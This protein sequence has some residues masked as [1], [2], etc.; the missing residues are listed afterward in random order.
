MIR[1]ERHTYIE[2]DAGHSPDFVSRAVMD[3][4]GV[5]RAALVGVSMG[6]S[7]AISAAVERP[8]RVAA[9]VVVNPG[10]EGF[11][12]ERDEWASPLFRR[13][14]E[15]WEAGDKPGVARLEAEVWLAGPHRSLDDMPA[16][17]VTRMTDW[18]LVSYE[19]EAYERRVK[20]ERPAARG[21]PGS[22][23]DGHAGSR[24]CV[25][26]GVGTRT[27]RQRAK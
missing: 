11:E 17:M 1:I 24:A 26:G 27:A 3:A 8:D 18:L 23:I 12:G 7:A 20:P 16:D 21:G 9:L 19:K 2:V 14:N 4:A 6:G 25:G 10:L 13:M 5:D 15:L 22:Q